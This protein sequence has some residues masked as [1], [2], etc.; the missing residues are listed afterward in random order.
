M[1]IVLG[2]DGSPGGDAA[3]RWVVAH[4]RALEAD[5]TAVLVIP[6]FEL[7]ELGALQVNSKH[8]VE[9][10]RCL[11]Q[12]AWTE[13]LRKAGLRVATRLIRGDPAFELCNVANEVGAELLVIGAKSHSA[14]RNLLGGTAHKVANHSSV[15]I[16]LVPSPAP[17]PLPEPEPSPMAMLRP[18]L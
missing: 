14:I 9:T 10:Y 5:I 7:W 1:R 8:R 3:A 13:P 6:R 18:F 12:G 17:P 4:S 11:L 16:V 2:L 15:P